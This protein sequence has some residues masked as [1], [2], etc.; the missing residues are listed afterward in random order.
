MYEDCE[1]LLHIRSV[2]KSLLL[3]ARKEIL[4]TLSTGQCSL[5]TIAQALSLGDRSLQRRLAEN[6]TSFEKLVDEVR[7]EL[8]KSLIEG[9]ELSFSEIAA[10]AGYSSAATLSR[11]ARVWFGHPPAQ[12]R[13]IGADRS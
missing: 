12:L 13:R 4:A 5:K 2:E 6:N 8:V 9:S 1:K 7:Q 3:T 10:Q 11:A